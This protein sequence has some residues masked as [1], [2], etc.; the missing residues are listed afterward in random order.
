MMSDQINMPRRLALA[1]PLT[2]SGSFGPAC[3][4][5]IVP[6]KTHMSAWERE[7]PQRLS[8]CGEVIES[9]ENPMA[10]WIELPGECENAYKKQAE[11]LIRRFYDYARWCWQSPSADVRTLRLPAPFMSICR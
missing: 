3:V 5:S 4:S 6:R 9:A 8:E 10:L 7:G 11:D 1:I 2:R